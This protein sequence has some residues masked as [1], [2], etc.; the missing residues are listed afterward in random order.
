[1]RRTAWTIALL[2]VLAWTPAY[3]DPQKA[4][5]WCNDAHMQQ[6]DSSITAMTDAEKQKEAKSH[7]EMSREAMQKQDMPGCVEHMQETRKAMGL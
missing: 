3:A 1:M 6:M 5:A 2:G 4:E 7:L